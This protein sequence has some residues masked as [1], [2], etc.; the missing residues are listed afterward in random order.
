MNVKK[1]NP[2]HNDQSHVVVWQGLGKLDLPLNLDLEKILEVR[3]R[4]LLAPLALPR[5]FLNRILRS[6][7]EA[8]GRIVA[9]VD[10]ANPVRHIH[11]HVFV[12]QTPGPKGKTWGFFRVERLDGHAELPDHTIELYLYMEH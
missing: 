8:T 3:L 1:I 10:T 4:E 11:I 6:S 12:P 9:A 5:D 2:S 7:R